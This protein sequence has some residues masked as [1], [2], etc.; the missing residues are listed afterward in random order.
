MP[1]VPL[2]DSTLKHLLH[3]VLATVIVGT[4]YLA[5]EILMPLTAAVL[6]AFVLTP[7]VQLFRRAHL[8]RAVAVIAAVAVALGLVSVAGVFL[9]SQVGALAD[10]LPQY[11]GTIQAKVGDVAH[12]SDSLTSELKARV[13]L[14]TPPV[15]APARTAAQTRRG[16]AVGA[17]ATPIPGPPAAK[18]A[19]TAWELFQRVVAPTL[20]P[21]ATAGLIFVVAI[22][23]LLQQGDLRDRLI[24]L[25]GSS[26][27]HRTTLALDDA[28][29]RLSRYFASQFVVNASF[30][31]VV[32][33]G[34]HLIG[35]PHS[36]LFGAL[37]AVLRYIPYVGTLTS[38]V[39][40]AAM[41]AA[42]D[43]GWAL[44]VWTLVLFVAA[45]LVTGQLVEPLLYGHSTGLTPVSI[46]VAAVFWTW[47]WG[48]I[49]LVL[50]TPLSLCLLV[51]GR[52]VPR[53]SFFEVILGDSA[54]LSPVEI[55]YQRL[56]GGNGDDALQQANDLL[57]TMSLTD[58]YDTVALNALLTAARDA[59]RGSV[60][61]RQ[62]ATVRATAEGL[63]A[64]LS[65][66]ADTIQPAEKATRA[67]TKAAAKAVQAPRGLSV[68]CLAGPGPLDTLSAMI[69]CQV[70]SKQG[71]DASLETPESAGLDYQMLNI[72]TFHVAS[73][74][75]LT[76]AM[77]TLAAQSKGRPVIG[78]ILCSSERWNEVE[79]SG[80]AAIPAASL[81]DTV[82]LCVVATVS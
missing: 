6:L 62:L 9:V 63:I 8:P 24:R 30:G 29:A 76:R 61:R 28:G 4:L 40:S 21:F 42:V 43:P 18:P 67:E 81:R 75:A 73:S 41:A 44:L 48:P 26:D 77:T 5:R 38:A 71:F 20:K 52:H 80:L 54:P 70:L 56:L 17:P 34:L 35:L 2:S 14:A 15:A 25:V 49:G 32:A 57:K 72:S 11:Q 33:L 1:I 10:D 13:G 79:G 65:S 69:V 47:L 22:F 12:L 51:L 66:R 58:Y 23:T 68:R 59:Q 39:I 16:G 46:V 82:D 50:S 36:L 7:L 53:L 78:T 19:L 31:V 37:A 60:T 74:R 64:A 55:C 45:D 3:V 27:L